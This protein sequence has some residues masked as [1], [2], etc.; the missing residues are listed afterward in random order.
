MPRQG[1]VMVHG[2]RELN[3]AYRFM[4]KELRK[5]VR[6]ELKAVG[7]PVRMA[8]EAKATAN[9]TNIGDRWS[10]MR[11]GVT[12]KVGYVAPKARRRKGTPASMGRPKFAVL[13]M[14][15]AMIPAL[16]ESEPQTIR[17]FE[18]MLDR[19]ADKGGF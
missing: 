6:N 18:Q 1:Q 17:S 2:L 10:Q 13:L 7:E 19:L 15:Q 4:D 8:A 11:V 16:S 5:D 3:R 12:T 9:I 14:E